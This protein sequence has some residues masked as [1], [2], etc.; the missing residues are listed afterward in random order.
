ME[1]FIQ[2]LDN[3]QHRAKT[4]LEESKNEDDLRRRAQLI[5]EIERLNSIT[6]KKIKCLQIAIEEILHQSK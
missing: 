4:M 2:Q 6:Q 3:L 5:D 1:K